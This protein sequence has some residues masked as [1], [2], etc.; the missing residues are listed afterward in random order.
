MSREMH[1]WEKLVKH[2]I[3]SKVLSLLLL[4]KFIIVKTLS[5]YKA[6][7]PQQMLI[8]IYK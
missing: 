6:L 2:V 5:F 3:V 4:L 7:I 1:V 8:D